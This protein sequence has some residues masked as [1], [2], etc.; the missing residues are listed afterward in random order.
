MQKKEPA[1]TNAPALNSQDDY[2]IERLHI[3]FTHWLDL[4]GGRKNELQKTWPEF[5]NW[6]QK[7]PP[8]SEKE[9]AKLIK[10]ALFGDKRSPKD[11]LRHNDNVLEITGIEGDYDAEEMQ[12]EIAI[13]LLEGFNLK[14]IIATSFS[15]AEDKPRFRILAPLKNT[16]SPEKRLRYIEIINGMLG[17]VLA[18]ESATLS[19]S[20]FIGGAVGRP[21]KVLHT[22]DD[23]E[24]GH[25]LDELD[26]FDDLDELRK[27]FNVKS[28]QANSGIYSPSK[29][30]SDWVNDLC[31]G[32]SV[33]PSMVRIVSHYIAKGWE[34]KDIKVL[35]IGLAWPPFQM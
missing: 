17:G 13:E 8:S 10:L 14:A 35:F 19:Q 20:Y 26:Q 15:S 24:E 9:K 28:K 27:P 23:P 3:T 11:S 1:Q 32:E 18:S 33:H 25:T 22:F 5:Y 6:L 29:E 2:S 30:Y 12:P 21:Y 16:V 34:D 31:S 7:I 4:S